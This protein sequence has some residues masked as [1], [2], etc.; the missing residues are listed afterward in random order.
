VAY[1]RAT[2]SDAT[3]NRVELTDHW[4]AALPDEGLRRAYPDI[5]HND[6]G[7]TPIAV[8]GLWRDVPEFSQAEA[9]LY[10]NKFHR[11]TAASG[12]RTWLGFDGLCYQGDI[13]LD[14][15][16]LGDT[17]GYF[18]PHVFE[19]TDQIAE[20]TSHVL[21]LEAVCRTPTD[22]TAKRNITGIL[23]HWDNLD[24]SLNPG[25]LWRNVWLE[26]TGPVRISTLRMSVVEA[27]AERAIVEFNATLDCIATHTVNL[28]TFIDP[29]ANT[30]GTGEVAHS[31]DEHVLSA[32]KNQLEWRIAIDEP[33]LWWPHSLGEP[34]LHDVRVDV[35]L[36]GSV[37][38]TRKRRIGFRSI[39]L[40]NWIASVNGERLHLKGTNLGPVKANLSEVT[41]DDCAETLQSVRDFGLDLVRIHGH[42][43]PPELYR[44]ADRLGLLVWQDF[45][46]QWSYARGIKSEAERQATAMVDQLAHHP[47]IIIWCGHN[48]PTPQ[49]ARPGH[50]DDA[51][52][53]NRFFRRGVLR[54]ELP[55]WNRTV[56]DRAVK[57]AI[58]SADPSR[59]VIPHSG[60]LPHP[61]QLDGTDSH[62]YFGWFQGEADGLGALAARIPRMTRFVSEF[63]AQS[64][65]DLAAIGMADLEHAPL[66][67]IDWEYLTDTL[68]L[69]YDIA[70]VRLP[71]DSYTTFG[72]WAQATRDHHCDVI[73]RQIETLRRLKYR[74]NGG[75]CQFY[76]ADAQPAISCSVIDHTGTE[77]QAAAALRSGCAP[78]LPLADPLPVLSAAG[79]DQRQRL[80]VVS[81]LREDLDDARLDVTLRSSLGER[82]WRFDGL[83]PADD[84]VKIGDISWKSP[85]TN[86][87]VE[88][89]LRLLAD[90][91]DTVSTYST[92]IDNRLGTAR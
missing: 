64:V 80:H 59:P 22:L 20:S 88:V 4:V 50:R 5:H 31:I 92:R 44:E 51:E 87:R 38:H 18:A 40:R 2:M 10:R 25:G 75:W 42:I 56:L 14:G 43:A 11:D 19:I 71:F 58:Q 77:K 6:T 66:S 8:P 63:G 28:H 41:A 83:I 65:P 72:Q 36:A 34:T 73:T 76:F 46:L 52:P 89:E 70:K 82:R 85:I 69:H 23:Q 26:D 3:A 55:S 45:P 29:S 16:Y 90:G 39:E 12:T 49:T 37:S 1:R 91:I 17:E 13:W 53:H 27:D 60:V 81:D 74:P 62:L 78:V 32:G 79:V 21:A 67:E 61:P 54:Q 68:G 9:V 24:P 57:K 33:N 48:E 7:W 15:T 86:E 35:R 84:V 30:A 47:S